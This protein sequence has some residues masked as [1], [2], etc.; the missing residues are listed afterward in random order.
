MP[1]FYYKNITEHVFNITII[2]K[3]VITNS[4]SACETVLNLVPPLYAQN[5]FCVLYATI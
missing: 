5:K 3:K 2:M 4:V 1:N